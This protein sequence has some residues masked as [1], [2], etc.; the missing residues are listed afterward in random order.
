MKVKTGLV[1]SGGGARGIA[2]A[3]VLQALD[4]LGIKPDR[5]SGTSSG[6]IIGALYA[7]GMPP[8]KMLEIMNKSRI[9]EMK[10]ISFDFKGLLKSDVFRKLL[11]NNLSVNTF[12][13]L[14]IPLSVCATD[15]TNA[16]S[17]VFESGDLIEPVTASCTIPMVFSP[18]VIDHKTMVDGGLLN[19]LPI[20][21]LLHKCETIIGVHVNPIRPY[22]SGSGFS[23]ILERCFHMSVSNIVKIK[24]AKCDFFLE[25]EALAKYSVFDTKHARAI[26]E[27]GYEAAMEKKDELLAL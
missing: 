2:H 3:G 19:N 4:E 15:F 23:G 17:V 6:A 21:P 25:P 14:S 7:S 16:K 13:E 26:Y 22:K 18:V 5:I 24:A 9:F 1:L 27:I 11:R 10:G 8:K 12:E 20:E